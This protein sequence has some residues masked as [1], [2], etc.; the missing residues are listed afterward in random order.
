MKNTILILALTLVSLT[1]YTQSLVWNSA[2][3][4][5]EAVSIVEIG[6]T[7]STVQ[8]YNGHWITVNNT[9]LDFKQYEK[10]IKQV[11]RKKRIDA[12]KARWRANGW[13]VDV[14]KRV[15]YDKYGFSI[16]YNK[17]TGEYTREI[18]TGYYTSIHVPYTY[19]CTIK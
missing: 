14:I 8:Q 17:K 5:Y 12:R 4:T 19:K 3:D 15:G 10:D 6:D 13:Y 16:W 2:P 1:G 9:E 7:I 11:A 18:R